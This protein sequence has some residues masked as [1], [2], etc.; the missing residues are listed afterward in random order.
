M[1][2]RVQFP[3]VIKTL[4]GLLLIVPDRNLLQKFAFHSMKYATL[5]RG[6]YATDFHENSGMNSQKMEEKNITFFDNYF[7]Y[8]PIYYVGTGT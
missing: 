6:Q 7:T 1:F 3:D 5:L 2:E 4:T 8:L